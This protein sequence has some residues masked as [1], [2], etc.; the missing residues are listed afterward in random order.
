MSRALLWVP[1]SWIRI[2]RRP[3]IR[4][5]V[6]VGKPNVANHRRCG[7]AVT[8]GILRLVAGPQYPVEEWVRLRHKGSPVSQIAKFQ[9]VSP[10]VVTGQTARYGPFSPPVTR[11]Q[12]IDRRM[13]GASLAVIAAEFGCSVPWVSR[14]TRGG[15][16]YP[17]GEPDAATVAR[18]VELRQAKTR[19]A[20][21]AEASG[22]SRS[23]VGSA[24]KPFGPYPQPRQGPSTLWSHG[25]IARQFSVAGQT[26][27]QW[28]VGVYEFPDP[29]PTSR[30][31]RPMWAPEAVLE[32]ADTYL[33]P[34]PECPARILSV[35]K[36][37]GAVHRR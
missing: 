30:P 28:R 22:V 4:R 1:T 8:P 34:C 13:A 29:L 33:R 18:W 16:P 2:R 5:H 23:R 35:A 31:G 6:S 15:G 25:E 10:N 3:T 11:Q 27:S 17:T 21:I 7:R 14:M 19:I 24:T 36:H 26:V 20:D 9:G 37:L 12:I 32:W